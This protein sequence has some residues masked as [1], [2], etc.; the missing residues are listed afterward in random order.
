MN[1]LTIIGNLTRDPEINK[2]NAGM[3]YTKFSVA[4]QRKFKKDDGTHETDFLIARLGGKLELMLLLNI[5]KK[6]KKLQ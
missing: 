6:A 1:K 4:V 3:D 2:T 5:A